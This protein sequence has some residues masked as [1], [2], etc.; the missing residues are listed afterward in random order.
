MQNTWWQALWQKVGCAHIEDILLY[1]SYQIHYFI[2]II[3]QIWIILKTSWQSLQWLLLFHFHLQRLVPDTS[4][5]HKGIHS[6]S[7]ESDQNQLP[8]R[9]LIG[10]YTLDK[11]SLSLPLLA[12]SGRKRTFRDWAPIFFNV[13]ASF[14]NTNHPHNHM[15]SAWWFQPFNNNTYP[16]NLTCC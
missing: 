10:L 15:K 5:F 6:Q 7:G 1:K 8:N 12:L 2:L 11:E 9:T 14:W 4:D 13:P 16:L 3:R